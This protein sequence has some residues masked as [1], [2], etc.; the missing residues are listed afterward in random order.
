MGIFDDLPGMTSRAP[1]T[2]GKSGIFDGM[3]GLTGGQDAPPPPTGPVGGITMSTGDVPRPAVATS[4]FSIR[5]LLAVEHAGFMALGLCMGSSIWKVQATPRL[6]NDAYELTEITSAMYGAREKAVE[7]MRA[8]AATLG[9]DGVVGTRLEITQLADTGM[10]EFKAFGTAIVHMHN[11]AG[12]RRADGRPFTSDLSGQDF[13][14][15]LR[16]GRRPLDLVIGCCVQHI[17]RRG[18]LTTLKQVGQCVELDLFTQAYYTAREQAM[19]RMSAHAA[20]VGANEVI[21]T[22]LR[23]DTHIWGDHVVEFLAVGTAMLNT[24]TPDPGF[25]LNPT[26][27]LALDD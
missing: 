4:D 17:P 23:E 2:S 13:A 19:E 10:L 25:Q 21:G 11:H 27:T 22:A 6:S 1:D 26:F 7:I 3:P 24:G 8:E 16:S 5:E 9:A 12:Y 15:A 20:E 18:L 14:L